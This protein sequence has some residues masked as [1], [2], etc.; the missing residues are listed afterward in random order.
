[1]ASIVMAYIVMAYIVMAYIVMAY[2]V[3]AYIGMTFRVIAYIVVA[4]YGHGSVGATSCVSDPFTPPNC[5]SMSA[6]CS[7]AETTSPS[8]C[9]SVRS[10]AENEPSILAS[11]CALIS[12]S[13]ATTVRAASPCRTIGTYSSEHE[14]AESSAA[15]AKR[16][17]LEES[18]TWTIL[19]SSTS[20]RTYTEAMTI[21]YRP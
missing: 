6:L 21:L 9:A 11:P 3:M 4:L 7:A 12:C 10:S 14:R 13:T 19:P 2:I 16:T 20:C 1:M 18:G 8:S 15:A 17:S 5:A